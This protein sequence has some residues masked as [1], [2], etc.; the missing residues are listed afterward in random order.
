MRKDGDLRGQNERPPPSRSYSTSAV[1]LL[2]RQ[3]KYKC[4]GPTLTRTAGEVKE[5]R[6]IPGNSWRSPLATRSPAG[7]ARLAPQPQEDRGDREGHDGQ[8]SQPAQSPDHHPENRQHQP[9]DQQERQ[10]TTHDASIRFRCPRCPPGP[11]RTS[12]PGARRADR[13]HRQPVGRGAA[14]ARPRNG[15]APASTAAREHRLLLSCASRQL[16]HREVRLC[17]T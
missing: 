8:E 11:S 15:L 5:F 7:P 6:A 3:R 13:E 14:S 4:M 9:C 17:A 12:A 16:Q 1:G 2:S 10:E